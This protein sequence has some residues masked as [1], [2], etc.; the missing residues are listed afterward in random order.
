MLRVTTA[1]LCT[2]CQR[3][4]FSLT[5]VAPF[6]KVT[7]TNSRLENPH[8][9]EALYKLSVDIGKVRK[10]KSWVLSETSAYVSETAG[11]LREMGAD[12]SLIASI[13]QNHPEAI[14]CHPHDIKEQKN[15]W[16]SVCA[17]DRELISIIEKFPAAFF[18]MSHHENQ[19]ANIVY[20]QSLGLCK[21]IIGKV[22]ASAPQSFSQPV[23]RN[24]EV[25]HTLRETYL[26]LGGDECNLKVWLQKLLG[27]NPFV[28]LWPAAAWRDGLCFLTDQGF[29]KEEILGVVSRLR[30]SI[31][32]LQPETMHQA[33]SFFEQVLDCSKEELK[34]IVLCC[35]AILSLSVPTLVQRFYGLMD[36]GLNAEQIKDCP[37]VLELTTQMVLY[38]MHKLSSCGYDIHS[39]NLD[40]IVGSKRDFDMICGMLQQRHQKTMVNTATP[41]RSVE[42]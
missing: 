29:T 21:R 28:L 42:E 15:L 31:P 12:P 8:T 16:M 1:S 10:F 9:I 39:G 13:L 7:S 26:E 2:Y 3:I 41:L 40:I 20:L 27:H 37:A 5:P 24:K 25:I 14:L 18:M 38:R 23:Q 32:E 17:S 4:K 35:P 11:M 34:Q 6:S 19:R 22:M 36:I 33:L 30:A